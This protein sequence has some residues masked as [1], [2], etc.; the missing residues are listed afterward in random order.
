MM[1]NNL[2][3]YLTLTGLCIIIACKSDPSA[4]PPSAVSPVETLTTTPKY[5][6]L[7]I[8]DTVFSR[9]YG[10]C[11][12]TV[13]TGNCVNIKFEYPLAKGTDVSELINEQI[14]ASLSDIFTMNS[15]EQASSLS[16]DQLADTVIA[17]Y[18]IARQ[19]MPEFTMEY[20]F[21]VKG[22][23]LLQ[24]EQLV[25]IELP[26]YTFTGGAH[27]NSFVTLLNF[28]LDQQKL[29]ERDDIIADTSAL[30]KLGEAA[31]FNARKEDDAPK[32]V[33]FWDSDYFLPANIA[34]TD[35]GLY[36]YYNP[37]EAA[38]YVFGPTEFTLPYEQL[39][40]ILNPRY[41]PQGK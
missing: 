38:A 28:D 15:E 29:L 16:L 7:T 30:K 34:L 24:N 19:E 21:E 22:K 20:H 18:K 11:S 23:V 33:Y 13:L 12:D 41:L 35:K 8:I 2:L 4:T 9:T 40:G 39:K 27:P 25:S 5:T 6:S 36:F 14:Q 10:S 3:I 31:F 26:A 1:K 17:E 32:D 37:Y